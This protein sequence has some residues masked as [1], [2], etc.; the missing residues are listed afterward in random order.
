MVFLDWERESGKVSRME[1]QSPRS[2]AGHPCRG[3]GSDRDGRL[4]TR[5]GTDHLV[6]VLRTTEAKFLSVREGH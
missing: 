5:M 6:N 1:S 4:V 2:K 3:G